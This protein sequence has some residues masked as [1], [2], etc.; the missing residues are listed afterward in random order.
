M[1]NNKNSG[2]ITIAISTWYNATYFTVSCFALGRHLDKLSIFKERTGKVLFNIYS[3]YNLDLIID[4]IPKE[5]SYCYWIIF[6]Y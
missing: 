6:I 1:I 2:L 4:F 5:D 3:I